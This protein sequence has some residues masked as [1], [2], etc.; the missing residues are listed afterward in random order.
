MTPERA[1]EV[2]LATRPHRMA[3]EAEHHFRMV[4]MPVDVTDAEAFPEIAAA[5][6]WLASLSPERR[7]FLEGEWS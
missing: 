2:A 7:A 3:K 6:R 4:A 1:R 5:S